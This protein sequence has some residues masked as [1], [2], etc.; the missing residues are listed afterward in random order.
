MNQSET[1]IFYPCTL[2]MWREWLEKNHQSKQA[3]WVVFY[4]K[5]SKKNSITWSE[6]VDVALCFGWIDSKKIKIDDETS[7]QFFSKRKAKST[8]SKINKQKVEKLIASGLMTE[9]GHKSI[10]T[11]KQNGSW[12]ILDEVEELIV[13]SDLQAEFAIHPAA[14]E[15]FNS[16]SKS[17]KKGILQWLVLAKR[18]ETRQN[19]ITEII[20]RAKQKL[21]PKHL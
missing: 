16:L 14:K 6:A 10:A 13:P 20:E 12:T 9:E 3:V 8:W 15:F 7:H 2:S 18:S 19:R 11:A 4:R 1:E 21:K 17:V 5:S